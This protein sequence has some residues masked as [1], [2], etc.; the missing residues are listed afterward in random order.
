MQNACPV[1][2]RN[3]QDI[4]IVGFESSGHLLNTLSMFVGQRFEE[5]RLPDVGQFI[6]ALFDP[7]GQGIVLRQPLQFSIVRQQDF[8]VAERRKFPTRVSFHRV[9]VPITP[10]FAEV[11]QLARW[12][13]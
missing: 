2:L 8:C 13:M 5:T 7:T 1:L 10:G 4:A 6:H 9:V 12:N 3:G 11:F